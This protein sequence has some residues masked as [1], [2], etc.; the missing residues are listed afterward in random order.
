LVENRKFDPTIPL[1]GA[2]AGVIQLE[3][4][5]DFWNQKTR[6]PGHHMVWHCLC[7][8]R[9]SHLC[10]TSTCDRQTNRHM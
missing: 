9:F 3:F 10:R 2:P 5:R 1:L 7:D 4:R 6:V 8:P